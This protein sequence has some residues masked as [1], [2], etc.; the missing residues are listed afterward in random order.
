MKRA[1]KGGPKPKLSILVLV[2]DE[3]PR[4]PRFFAAL[5]PLGL[6]HEVL[7]V[8]SGSRDGSRALGA[9]LG[10]RVLRARWEG[11]ST[12]RNRAFASCKADWILVLDADEN[13]EPA[14]LAAIERALTLE[15][16]GPWSVNRLSNFLGQAVRHSGWHPDRHLRLFPKGSARF[17]DRLVHEGMESLVPGAKVRHLDGILRH[18][19]Y[20][21]LDSYL[22]RMNRYSTL[23]AEELLRRKGARPWTAGIRM[24]ADPPLTFL[25]MYVLKRGFLDGSTGLVLALLSGSSTFWK[26]AKWR[27]LSL[28]QA[29]APVP[30]PVPAPTHRTAA[31]SRK[32]S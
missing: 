29:S 13:P 17:N 10:G 11:F 25:K 24:F 2:K 6:P 20:P 18:D 3:A 12:T 21:D 15:P 22:A 5:K 8:D 4:L 30:V 7:L 31:G 1:A 19:S 23:Q 14:L 27:R 9:R 32:R 16:P 26:Y 28:D